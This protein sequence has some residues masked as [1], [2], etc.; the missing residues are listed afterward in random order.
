MNFKSLSNL[1]QRLI[2]GG[3]SILIALLAVYYSHSNLLGMLLFTLFISGSASA[4]L[5]E[6]Y[7]IA[8]GKG[9]LPLFKIGMITSF[10]FFFSTLFN[11]LVDTRVML[12]LITVGLGLIAGFIYYFIKGT[13]PFANLAVTFFG[14]LYLTIPLGSLIAINYFYAPSFVTDGRWCLLYL[15]LVTKGTDIGGFFIGKSIGKTQLSPYISPKK[16]WE[17]ALGGLVTSVIISILFYFA[18][19][20]FFSA[21]PFAI[22]LSESILFAMLVSVF[23]QF[24]DLAESLLKR[25]MG[26]KDSSRHLPGLGGFLDIQDSL[27]FTAPLMYIFLNLHQIKPL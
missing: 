11:S 15:I 26:V 24:G 18:F 16:T 7:R 3:G 12:P 27:V 20:N 14:I 10:A 1:Q 13:D 4:A 6:Y 21:P 25:D 2:L 17:G 23:G 8:E 19:K 9:Y 5:W 22:S